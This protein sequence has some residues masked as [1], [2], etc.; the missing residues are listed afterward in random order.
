MNPSEAVRFHYPSADTGSRTPSLPSCRSALPSSLQCWIPNGLSL[1]LR[2]LP[3]VDANISF[4]TTLLRHSSPEMNCT[5][6]KSAFWR[7]FTN[8]ETHEIT[9]A[10]KTL[11]FHHYK[12]SF[13]LLCF[14]SLLASPLPQHLSALHWLPSVHL[15]SVIIDYLSF[16]KHLI[17]VE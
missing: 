1:G 10:N 14:P 3:E 8:L 11:T 9:T 4:L 15:L 17:S 12:R 2:A 13:V 7:V 5:F 6:L 16:S